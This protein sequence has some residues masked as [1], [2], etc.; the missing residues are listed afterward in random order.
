MRKILLMAM[1]A[2]SLLV[3]CQSLGDKAEKETADT[4]TT[5]LKEEIVELD[6]VSTEVSEAT[7]NI[8]EA[9]REL[10]KELDDLENL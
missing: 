9:I 2:A 6:S 1:L 7:E 4:G 3:S 8:E 10:D 5:E